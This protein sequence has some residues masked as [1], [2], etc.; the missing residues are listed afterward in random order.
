M[1][2]AVMRAPV[3]RGVELAVRSWSGADEDSP[4]LLVHGLASNARLWDGVGASLAARGHR[5]AAVDLR[6][7]GQSGKPDD[8]YDFFT[9]TDDLVEVIHALALDRPVAVGQSLGGNLVVEL[10]HRR[11]GIVRGIAAVDGGT[12]ELQ[13]RFPAFDECLAALAPPNTEGLRRDEVEALL[14]ELHPGLPQ[15]AIEAT[16]AN[17]EVRTDGTVAP[18]LTRDRHLRLLRALWEHRPS[19]RYADL[20]VPVLLLPADTAA[21]APWTAHK[22]ADVRRAEATIPA[23]RTHWFA[24]AD[25]DVHA[26][27]PDA[28]ADLLHEATA[29][30]F[31]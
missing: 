5:V 23:V 3:G 8:G 6:G 27:F 17:F 10:A 19:T 29:E 30:F 26:Q 4:F 11:P 28:V 13:E 24:D 31:A 22:R 25:H 2:F 9:L 20:R 18:W 7:H 21:A 14:R 15:A 12:I 16:L 1:S